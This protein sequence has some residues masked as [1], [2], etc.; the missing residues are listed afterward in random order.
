MAEY[1]ENMANEAY[2]IDRI[3]KSWVSLSLHRKGWQNIYDELVASEKYGY[4]EDLENLRYWK[5]RLH[6]VFKT[7]CD[8]GFI[9]PNEDD[10]R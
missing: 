3:A 7:L 10:F 6:G 2:T 9:K 4:P 5:A 8:C 1:H